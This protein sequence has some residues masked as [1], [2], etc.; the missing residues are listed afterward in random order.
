MLAAITGLETPQAR[1]RAAFDATKTY[2][3]FFVSHQHHGGEDVRQSHLLFAQQRKM[4]QDLQRF[5]VGSKDD[6]FRNTAVES[7]SG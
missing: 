6:D 7:L 3:T 1:P 2:G 4:E 5:R